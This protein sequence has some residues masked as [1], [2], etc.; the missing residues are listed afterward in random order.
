VPQS[1]ALEDGMA[2]AGTTVIGARV[3]EIRALDGDQVALTV[4]VHAVSPAP[5]SPEG[6]VPG[7]TLRVTTSRRAI[8]NGTTVGQDVLL[9]AYLDGAAWKASR[10]GV[11]ASRNV[12]GRPQLVPRVARRTSSHL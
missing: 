1:K 10:V 8:P 2:D 11:P 5:M 4:D 9:I 12:S 3:A 7:A 6:A